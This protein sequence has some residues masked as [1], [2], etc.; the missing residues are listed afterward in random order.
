M[1]SLPKPVSLSKIH[2]QKSTFDKKTLRSKVSRLL[3]KYN[4]RCNLCIKRCLAHKPTITVRDYIK[5][6]LTQYEFH[7]V[8]KDT[9]FYIADS[10][11]AEAVL[12]ERVPI[13]V[14]IER[15]LISEHTKKEEQPRLVFNPPK[16]LTESRS[17]IRA[18][19]LSPSHISS[20]LNF[21][22]PSVKKPAEDNG[23]KYRLEKLEEQ[24]QQK[25][26]KIKERYVERMT[27]YKPKPKKVLLTRKSMSPT[28]K[29]T[30][31]FKRFNEAY[32]SVDNELRLSK[33][34]LALHKNR[35]DQLSSQLS[36][37]KLSRFL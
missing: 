19:N 11:I 20:E 7:K 16:L 26:Q 5:A 36:M 3:Q 18:F 25:I 17:Q 35:S 32:Y 12:D 24:Q 23:L 27:F 34:N 21:K 2:A 9:F 6:E 15:D 29:T 8:C 10:N 31:A 37:K 4:E 33:K 1:S 14:I 28:C 22:L 30:E 13:Q